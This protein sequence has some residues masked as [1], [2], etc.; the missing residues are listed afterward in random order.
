M[1]MLRHFFELA[2]EDSGSLFQ[3]LAVAREPEVMAHQGQYPVLYFSLK[4][5]RGTTWETAYDKLQQMMRV[6]A[7]Q[8]SYLESGLDP[9]D[10]KQLVEIAMKTASQGLLENS[11]RDLAIWLHRHHGKPVIILIDEYDTPLLEAYAHD[12]YEEMA[13]FMRS[14]L[15]GGLKLETA[16]GV[17]FKGVVTGIMRVAKESLFSGLNNLKTYPLHAGSPF[18]DK[19]GFTDPEVETLLREWNRLDEVDVVREWYNGYQSGAALVYNPWSIINYLSE[20]T[21]RCSTG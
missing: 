12:Y 21:A 11:L 9:T 7:T 15:G 3:D 8:F 6:A 19:F 2:E 13:S 20:E 5:I 4:E 16:P 18:S 14:W 1:Q 10:S 17:L